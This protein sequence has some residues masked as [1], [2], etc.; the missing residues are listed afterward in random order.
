VD[1]G[2][3][4]IWLHG[5]MRYVVAVKRFVLCIIVLGFCLTVQMHRSNEVVRK[6]LS[7]DFDAWMRSARRTDIVTYVP[8][9]QRFGE[10]SF[11][12]IQRLPA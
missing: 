2:K 8:F 6:I 1:D 11:S 5:S 7:K 12:K 4:C 9:F 3:A 10:S